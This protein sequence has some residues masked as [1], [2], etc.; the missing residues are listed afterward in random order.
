[1][2][3]FLTSA[4]ILLFQAGGLAQSMDD[5]IKAIALDVS[6]Q[7]VKKGGKK[8][9]VTALSYKE[10]DTEFGKFLAEELTG[11]LA[12]S[13]RNISVVNQKLLEKLLEQNKLTAKGLLEARNDA[14]KLGQVSGIDALVYGTVTT[15]GE[16]VRISLSIVKLPTLEVYGFAKGSFPLTAG[17]KQMLPCLST[18]EKEEVVEESKRSKQTATKCQGQNSV[19]VLFSIRECVL[20]GRNL[21]CNMDISNVR[22][23]KSDASF[24][25]NVKETYVV[26]NNGKQYPGAYMTVGNA[27]ADGYWS[28]NYNLVYGI[29]VK[30]TVGFNVE[31]SNIRSFQ[32]FEIKNQ[33]LRCLDVP[34]VMYGTL[35]KK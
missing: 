2:K 16:D 5:K 31:E 27:S 14:A 9:A 18:D 28:S 26:T 4:L 1:M 29:K 6:D 20:N 3:I 35:G 33:G 22:E 24:T 19:G 13:G 10:C 7:I 11:N 34:V 25:F 32:I 23:D 8:V 21:V 15:L 30:G 12:L 17:I